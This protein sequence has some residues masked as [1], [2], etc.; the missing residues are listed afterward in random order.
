MAESPAAEP[1]LLTEDLGPVRRLTMNRPKALNALSGELLEFPGNLFGL[2]SAL[3][4]LGS[5]GLAR[6]LARGL[7]PVARARA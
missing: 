3:L 2:A 7:A 6:G 1:V 5:F 4:G